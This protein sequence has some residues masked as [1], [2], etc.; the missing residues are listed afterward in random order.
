ML[1]SHSKYGVW[2]ENREIEAWR[3]AICGLEFVGIAGSGIREFG[4]V[5]GWL[6][7]MGRRHVGELVGLM[8]IPLGEKMPPSEVRHKGMHFVFF[9]VKFWGNQYLLGCSESNRL[10]MRQL[11]ASVYAL[12]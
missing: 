6:A 10:K 9:R 1:C 4:E 11:V 2:F 7:F 12:V 5:R 3:L 8:S